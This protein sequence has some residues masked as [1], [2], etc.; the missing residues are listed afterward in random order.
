[1]NYVLKKVDVAKFAALPSQ[2]PISPSP[3]AL[4]PKP[5][6]N[7]PPG[8]K[9]NKQIVCVFPTYRD[10][11]GTQ[12]EFELVYTDGTKEKV[13]VGGKFTW[14]DHMGYTHTI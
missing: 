13:V 4:P 1:M 11:G 12:R 6:P 7:L 9:P 8:S 2:V 10:L 3:K 14:T 5:K